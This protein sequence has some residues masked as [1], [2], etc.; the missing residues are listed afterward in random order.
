MAFLKIIEKFPNYAVNRV[1]QVTNVTTGRVLKG[2]FAGKGYHVVQLHHN[3]VST[4]QYM[5]R[6]VLDTF[7]GPPPVACEACHN[8]GIRTDNRLENLRWDTRSGNFADKPRHGT[9]NRGAKHYKSKLTEDDVDLIRAM[10]SAGGTQ[11]ALA[12]LYG[13]H[14]MTINRINTGRHWHP[15]LSS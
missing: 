3:G 9:D 14:H 5:H 2:S 13:V 1:G 6:L 15:S 4:N 12:A 10:L 7:V 8:N 11:K